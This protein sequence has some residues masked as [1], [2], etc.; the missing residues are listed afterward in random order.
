MGIT[1][2]QCQHIPPGSQQEWESRA[3]A[4]AKLPTMDTSGVSSSSQVRSWQPCSSPAFSTP[5]AQAVITAT[6][7]PK[8][9]LPLKQLTPS[10]WSSP[11][12]AGTP[13]APTS[14][15]ARGG[16]SPAGQSQSPGNAG[17]SLVA[18]RTC[19]G[20]GGHVPCPA[21]GQSVTRGKP[22]Q[23]SRHRSGHNSVGQGK[24]A[25][26]PCATQGT[27]LHGTGDSRAVTATAAGCQPCSPGRILN[28]C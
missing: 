16:W 21:K 1:G 8:A 14:G 9:P 17:N 15:P 12:H 25:L 4:P 13:P 20:Q 26:A 23:P 19:W 6:H 22:P 5:P 24:A 7:G 27:N 3:T 18:T 28:T 10:T 11:C 2:S